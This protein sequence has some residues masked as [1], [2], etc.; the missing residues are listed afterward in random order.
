M[1]VAKDSYNSD[2]YYKVITKGFCDGL[3]VSVFSVGW[4]VPDTA[5]SLLGEDDCLDIKLSPNTSADVSLLDFTDTGTMT[6]VIC[7]AMQCN[8]S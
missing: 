3:A 7:V 2:T 6:A 5:Y 8:E 1:G 4:A